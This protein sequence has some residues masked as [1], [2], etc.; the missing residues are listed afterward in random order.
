MKVW[1]CQE[2]IDY[3]GIVDF[4]LYDSKEKAFD[5]LKSVIEGWD[6]LEFK[7]V[8]TGKHYP[9]KYGTAIIFEQVIG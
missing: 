2:D 8:E 3:E 6:G 9:T 4:D 7:H 5:K 1:V